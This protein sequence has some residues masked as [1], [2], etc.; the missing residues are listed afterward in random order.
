MKTWK[1]VVHYTT[2]AYTF[3]EAETEEEAKEMIR[4]EMY[5]DLYGECVVVQPHAI[6]VEES[7]E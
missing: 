5:D 7:N 1:V 2:E 4:D 6:G 3:V